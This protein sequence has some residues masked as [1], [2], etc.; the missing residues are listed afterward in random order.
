MREELIELSL[1]FLRF[2]PSKIHNVPIGKFGYF[3]KY[4]A[5]NTI[6]AVAMVSISNA[7]IVKISI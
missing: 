3:G 1:R 2:I 4:E 7:V 5:E 6:I